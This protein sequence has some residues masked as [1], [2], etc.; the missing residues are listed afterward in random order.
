M[1]IDA[2]SA[3]ALVT[4]TL[5]S[6]DLPAIAAVTADITSAPAVQPSKRSPLLDQVHA[7]AEQIEKFLK[8]TGRE[9]DFHVDSDTGQIVVSV[10]DAVS[11]DLIRQMPS[12]EALHLAQTLGHGTGALVD[13][14]A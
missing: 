8:S 11:G 7:A 4:Q 1:S 9:L 10:R 2:L 5:Q 12:E 3:R 14:V 13:L 6:K